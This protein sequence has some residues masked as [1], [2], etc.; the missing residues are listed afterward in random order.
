MTI[1]MPTTKKRFKLRK[2]P[3][4]LRLYFFH[5]TIH[6]RLPHITRSRR[7]S[8]KYSGLMLIAALLLVGARCTDKYPAQ[9]HDSQLAAGNSC[10]S[11]HTNA[12]LLKKVAVPLP[13]PSVEA[14]EG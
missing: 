13:P 10:V 5:I 2:I 3:A 12:D 4:M 6:L 14:G 1:E 8:V 11:C 9:G 7:F